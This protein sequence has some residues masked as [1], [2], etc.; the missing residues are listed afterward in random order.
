[1]RNKCKN[2]LKNQRFCFHREYLEFRG[3][4]EISLKPKNPDSGY[5]YQKNL[6]DLGNL[7]NLLLCPSRDIFTDADICSLNLLILMV[8]SS[9]ACIYQLILVRYIKKIHLRCYLRYTVFERSR[10]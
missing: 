5:S 8:C 10:Y 4:V 7:E 9:S 3:N 6:R 1:M 2:R